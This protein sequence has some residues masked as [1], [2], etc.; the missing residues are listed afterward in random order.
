[1]TVTG[2]L[3]MLPM[4]GGGP[5]YPPTPVEVVAVG[6]TVHPP[7]CPS[8]FHHLLNSPGLPSVVVPISI[9][10]LKRFNGD[11]QLCNQLGT[12]RPTEGQRAL[13]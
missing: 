9:K 2:S 5:S 4:T 6:Y 13:L 11:E 7:G 8:G 10:P 12:E 1:V 3:D